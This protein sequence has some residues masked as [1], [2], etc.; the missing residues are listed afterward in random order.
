L[1]RAIV[2]TGLAHAEW[3]SIEELAEVLEMSAMPIRGA[4]RLLDSVTS[5]SLEAA[6]AAER[7]LEAQPRLADRRGVPLERIVDA[8]RR[9]ARA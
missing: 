8:S 4:L 9:L 1:R 2:T 6:L 5:S 7:Q 3:L